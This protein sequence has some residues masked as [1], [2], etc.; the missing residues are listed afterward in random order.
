MLKDNNTPGL[1]YVRIELA[2]K[3]TS[4]INSPSLNF[5]VVQHS[6][7]ISAVLN[8]RNDLLEM[9]ELKLNKDFSDK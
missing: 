4:G 7:G 1:L 5:N 3:A 2:E 8:D 9:W 6:L